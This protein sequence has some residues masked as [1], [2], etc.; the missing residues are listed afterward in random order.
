[1]LN[2][3]DIKKELKVME[4]ETGLTPQDYYIGAGSGLTM[5]GLRK[6]TGDIDTAVQICG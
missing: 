5:L 6:E 1:M 2:K 3:N 4:K